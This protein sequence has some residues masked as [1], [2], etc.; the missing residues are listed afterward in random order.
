MCVIIHCLETDHRAHFLG[1]TVAALQGP[2][3]AGLAGC[4]PQP[5]DVEIRAPSGCRQ[6]DSKDATVRNCLE[7]FRTID[8]LDQHLLEGW[9][10]RAPPGPL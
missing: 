10:P 4:Q 8:F 5:Q 1:A 6:I 2:D 3:V 9:E 7:V